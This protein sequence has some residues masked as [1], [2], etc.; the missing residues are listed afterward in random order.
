MADTYSSMDFFRR[1]PLAQKR[2][3]R[4][5]D[6][7]FSLC[8]LVVLGPLLLVIYAAVRLADP[9]PGIFK[10]TRVG[11]GG[12][13][14]VCLKFRTMVVDGEE[15]LR[16]FLESNEDI[17]REWLLTHKLRADPR[18][19]GLGSL[20]RLSSLDELPQ[21]LNVLIGDM[22]LV[23]PRPIVPAEMIRYGDRLNHY[24]AVKP[25]I[26]GLWQVSGR[27]ETTYD[28]RVALDVSYVEQWSL[29]RDLL[30]LIKT[31]PVVIARRG[32]C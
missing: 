26:T 27:S 5:L 2:L 32:S 18:I 9:G 17:R 11:K 12:R 10:Q 24:L 29:V 16:Q 15:R 20:L 14:F 1:E 4:L 13:S 3:K 21:L 19:S 30:I 8:L 31:V 22:S 6:I 28:E 7:I 23:G 25:G